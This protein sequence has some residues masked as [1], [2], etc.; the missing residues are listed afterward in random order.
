MSFFLKI[1]HFGH[2]LAHVA[3]DGRVTTGELIDVLKMIF[4]DH[5]DEALEAVRDKVDEDETVGF[6]EVLKVIAAIV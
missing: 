1:V 4:P 3:K 2:S 5:I 6:D